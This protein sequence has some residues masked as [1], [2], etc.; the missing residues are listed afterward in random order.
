MLTI[1][2]SFQQTVRLH[3]AFVVP[4][5]DRVPRFVTAPL[6]RHPRQYCAMGDLQRKNK[7]YEHCS[8]LSR[9]RALPAIKHSVRIF[10]VCRLI[11]RKFLLQVLFED[12]KKFYSERFHSF[13][14]H[15]P[16]ISLWTQTKGSSA[17]TH[18]TDQA[19]YLVQ[20][21]S[22]LSLLWHT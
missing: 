13:S 10:V 11:T 22:S 15:P 14:T 12:Y 3:F 9:Q 21:V 4:K 2:F 17:C 16:A 8:H 20:F 7:L 6:H 5:H 19:K 18:G 1:L